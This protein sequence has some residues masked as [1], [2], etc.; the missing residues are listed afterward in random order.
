MFNQLIFSS[1]DIN[2]GNNVS[3]IDA[4]RAVSASLCLAF[5]RILK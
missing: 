3:R 2:F 4:N 5:A 1:P